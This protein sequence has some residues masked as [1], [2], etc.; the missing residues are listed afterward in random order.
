MQEPE[1]KGGDLGVRLKP[2]PQRER[3]QIVERLVDHRKPDDGVDDIAVDTDIEPDARQHGHRMPDGKKAD[4]GRDLFHPIKKE[5]HAQQKQDVVISRHHVLGPKVEEGDDLH[6]RNL[7]DIALVAKRNGMGKGRLR[8]DRHQARQGQQDQGRAW[9]QS[10]G[11]GASCRKVHLCFLIGFRSPFWPFGLSDE[12]TPRGSARPVARKPRLKRR[13]AE[14][15][16]CRKHLHQSAATMRH[17]RHLQFV[18][19]DIMRGVAKG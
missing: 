15:W 14:R 19:A 6:P 8:P 10:C 12:E 4:I 5:D 9:P 3:P 13:L 11:P 7:M 16:H 2:E 17:K 18:V 1:D